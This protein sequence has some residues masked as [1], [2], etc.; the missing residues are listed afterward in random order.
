MAQIG[1]VMMVFIWEFL[2][3]ASSHTT[4][5]SQSI[6]RALNGIFGCNHS[7]L[8][9]K[10]GLIHVSACHHLPPKCS[11]L[12]PGSHCWFFPFLAP[13][14]LLHQQVASLHFFPI[15]SAPSQTQLPS[16]LNKTPA[17]APPYFSLGVLQVNHSNLCNGEPA[18]VSLCSKPLFPLRL[19]LPQDELCKVYA[20]SKCFPVFPRPT[21]SH[22]ALRVSSKEGLPSNTHNSH[23]C[24]SALICF[25]HNISNF[26][27][28]CFFVSFSTLRMKVL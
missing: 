12:E 25:F 16:S 20:P 24:L 11:R 13:P 26:I 28:I 15:S 5:Q 18:T 3:I 23:Y 19:L 10:S 4:I 9:T 6:K 27:T 7:I 14:Y 22:L 2:L 8:P 17:T 1:S 21:P